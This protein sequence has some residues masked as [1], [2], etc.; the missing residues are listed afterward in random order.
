MN[1]RCIVLPVPTRRLKSAEEG[2][3]K[4][5]NALITSVDW[6]QCWETPSGNLYSQNAHA[7]NSL[8]AASLHFHSILKLVLACQFFI[9]PLFYYAVK[10]QEY[11]CMSVDCLDYSS[12][13]F[14]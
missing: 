6:D 2:S 9:M 4:F 5:F 1:T 7:L 10:V 12:T 11:S 8:E 13:C 3:F 14:V